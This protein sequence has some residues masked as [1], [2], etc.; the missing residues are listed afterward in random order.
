MK[1]RFLIVTLVFV[2]AGGL[3]WYFSQPEEKPPAKAAKAP[4]KA[5]ATKPEVVIIPSPPT[6]STQVV[7]PVVAATKPSVTPEPAA[8]PAPAD[9]RDPQPQSD[10]N[11]VFTQSIRLIQAGDM[12]GIIKTL[13]PPDEMKSMMQSTGASSPEDVVSLLRQRMPGID[14]KMESLLQAMQQVQGQ[15]PDISADGNSATYKIEPPVDN[16][17]DLTFTKVDGN[18]YLK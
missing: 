14:A 3:G 16:Q 8:T 17:N 1:T 12:V 7:A 10:L 13:M 11:S 9:L 5:E 18:W 2:I 6:R 4:A 15:S